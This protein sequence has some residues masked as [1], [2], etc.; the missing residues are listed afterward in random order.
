VQSLIL[1]HLNTAIATE[2]IFELINTGCRCRH[3][4][5]DQ[6]L[7]KIQIQGMCHDMK[8]PNTNISC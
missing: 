4:K 8:A 6:I 5:E 1:N 2:D 3:E 7:D